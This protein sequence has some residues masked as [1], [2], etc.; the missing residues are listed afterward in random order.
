[1]SFEGIRGNEW[2]LKVLALIEILIMLR[3]SVLSPRSISLSLAVSKIFRTF[4]LGG[5]SGYAASAF[6]LS[7]SFNN[8]I[9]K[10]RLVPHLVPDICRNRAAR[11]WKALVI[12]FSDIKKTK[13]AIYRCSHRSAFLWFP[14]YTPRKFENS[15]NLWSEKETCSRC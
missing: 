4:W 8:S 12:C 1:M 2:L 11:I 3:L 14:D 6:C 15:T 13:S 5:L 9:F 7:I 10:Y